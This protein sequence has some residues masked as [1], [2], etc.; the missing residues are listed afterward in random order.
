MRRLVTLFTSL[1]AVGSVA[2]AQTPDPTQA[3]TPVPAGENPPPPPPTEA[4]PPPPV[5]PAPPPPAADLPKKVAVGKE[6]PSSFFAPYGLFQGWYIQDISKTLPTM[7]NPDTTSISTSTFRLRRGEVGATGELV[8]GLFK[9]RIVWDASR[10]RDVIART[11]V[12]TGVPATGAAITAS[13]PT[14]QTTL[15]AMNDFFL[16]LSTQFADFTLGQFKI[17]VSMDG[18]TS[19]TRLL[20]PERSNV[21][22]VY[23][24]KRDIGLRI[25]KTFKMFSYMIQFVDGAGQDVLDNNNQKDGSVRI[26]I[27]PIPGLTIGGMTYNSLGYRTIV[28][29]KDRYEGDLN[30][31]N[32]PLTIHA[33]YIRGVDTLTQGATAC[34]PGA[35]LSGKCTS[36]GVFGAVAFTLPNVAPILADGKSGDIQFVARVSYYDP[37]TDNDVDKTSAMTATASAAENARTDY[38]FGVNYY[39]RG[40]E[41]KFQASYDRQQFADTDIKAPVN[42]VIFSTQLTF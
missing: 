42:E 22:E 41:V 1:C 10:V 38:E 9:Y 14:P 24:D 11:T 26:G 37:D 6:T 19:S 12:V 30:Y 15:S 35:A 13:I 7:T 31:E 32:G 2:S 8:P 29:T 28:G 18:Y 16:T 23:G 3:T 21:T 25:D 4:P 36:Q 27:T 33:E 20:L 40:N 34:K 17:P 5:E 39:A